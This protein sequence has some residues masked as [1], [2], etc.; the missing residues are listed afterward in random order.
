LRMDSTAPRAVSARLAVAALAE[1]ELGEVFI[2][3]SELRN[4]HYSSQSLE[5]GYVPRAEA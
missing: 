5:R 4:V 1:G 2:F 3:C